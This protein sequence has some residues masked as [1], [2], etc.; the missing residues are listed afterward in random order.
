MAHRPG[1]CSQ[2]PHIVSREPKQIHQGLTVRLG[3]YSPLQAAFNDCRN[4]PCCILL[5][6]FLLLC[7][8]L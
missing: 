7:E 2:A 3:L 8:S 6:L 1:F 5:I 4:A